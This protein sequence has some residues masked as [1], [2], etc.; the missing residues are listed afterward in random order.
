MTEIS[1][2]MSVLVENTVMQEELRAEHGFAVWLETPHGAILWDTGQSPLCIENSRKMGV[3]I[4]HATGIAL[5]HGHYDHT[6]GLSAILVLNPHVTV[7]GH[8]D[9]FVQRY[10]RIRDNFHSMKPIGSPIVK[11]VVESKCQ[12][13]KLNQQPFEIVPGI[14]L[15]GEIP[16]ITEYEN[17]GGDF[18]LDVDCTVKDTIID[19]QALFFETSQGI[20]ILLG[21]AHAGVINTINHVVKFTGNNRI[22]AVLGGMHLLHASDERLEKTANT[23]EKYDVQMI[24]PCHCSGEIAKAFF[25]ARFPGRIISCSTGTHITFKV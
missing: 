7:Y 8:T 9:C 21:C 11:K 13:L 24:G 5:S 23:L 12:S 2:S 22:Y 19:D 17:T 20:V 10:V 25:R 14:F 16:R 1:I 6:G 3:Q 18:Y 4:E 15:T